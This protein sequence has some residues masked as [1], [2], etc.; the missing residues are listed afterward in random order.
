MNLNILNNIL[1]LGWS[2]IS[3]SR[4]QSATPSSNLNNSTKST[5]QS[6]KYKKRSK[7]SK[8]S[9][10]SLI[11]KYNS[12]YSGLLSLLKLRKST[13]YHQF[14]TFRQSPSRTTRFPHLELPPQ[15]K[16]ENQTGYQRKQTRQ[17]YHLSP[18]NPDHHICNCAVVTK[19]HQTASIRVPKT[20]RVREHW[21]RA[22]SLGSGTYL[23]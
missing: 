16:I 13:H 14:R 20:R 1:Q 4:A 10:K 8:L 6:T 9:L 21:V 22:V 15:E 5:L 17:R 2:S 7:H 3:F 11:S 12:Y 23:F 19:R 18:L